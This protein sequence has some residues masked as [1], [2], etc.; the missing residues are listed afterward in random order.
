V[1]R[2][3]FQ[4]FRASDASLADLGPEDWELFWRWGFLSFVFY[5][6][7]ISNIRRNG[8]KIAVAAGE[9]SGDAFYTETPKPQAEIIWC[10]RHVCYRTDAGVWRDLGQ[11]SAKL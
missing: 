6:P 8:V 1:F 9:K 5:T 2:S 7:D 10:L 3:E 11:S 4:A